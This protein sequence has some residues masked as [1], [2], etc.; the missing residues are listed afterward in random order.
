M[1]PARFPVGHSLLG[2]PCDLT[3]H[4]LMSSIGSGLCFGVLATAMLGSGSQEPDSIRHIWT[5]DQS[6]VPIQRLHPSEA[7]YEG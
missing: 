2:Q 6:C 1:V 3:D 4:S 7:T 5:G